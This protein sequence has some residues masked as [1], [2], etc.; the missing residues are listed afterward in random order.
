MQ[1]GSGSSSR[2]IHNNV[3]CILG[4]NKCYCCSVILLCW[5]CDPI[6]CST[7]ASLSPT[8]FRSLPKFMSITSVMSSN[9]LILCHPSL[10]LPSVLP[11]LY[12]FQWADFAW[13]GQSI[14][15]SASVLPGNTQHWSPL[16]W[17]GLISLQSKGLSR[18]FSGTTVWKHQ[19]FGAL[20]SLWSSS[21]NSTW[22]LERP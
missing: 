17:T 18:V 1:Q 2:D 14:G 3:M 19:F 15:A 8:I 9:Q 11:S 16:G 20:P 21:H 4:I 6:N 13:G 12:L 7:Q 22:L 10:P 5:L